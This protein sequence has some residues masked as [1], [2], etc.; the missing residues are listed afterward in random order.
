MGRIVS[1]LLTFTKTDYPLKA[2]VM[3][4]HT[5][6]IELVQKLN[7]E[8]DD[9]MPEPLPGMMLIPFEFRST[10][11][12]CAVFFVDRHVWGNGDSDER[13]VVSEAGEHDNK[14]DIYEDL[15]AYIRQQAQEIV[16][17]LKKVR[18]S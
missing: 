7:W 15:E 2:E 17:Q 4:S 12:D 6:I 5:E 3:E 11:E 14:D 9:K 16:D 10:G 18:W 13:A 1:S 8:Y